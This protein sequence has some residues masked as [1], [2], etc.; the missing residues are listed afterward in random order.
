[1][2]KYL[3]VGSRYADSTT[4][5]GFPVGHI[6]VSQLLARHTLD[7][8]STYIKNFSPGDFQFGIELI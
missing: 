8:D 1:M 7:R 2:K 3:C 4:L 6:N 5:L